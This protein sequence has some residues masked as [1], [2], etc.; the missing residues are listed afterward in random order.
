MSAHR[1]RAAALAAA[2]LSFAACREE[3]SDAYGTF[4][5]AEVVVSAEVGGQLL[6]FAPEEGERVAAG[7]LVAAVDTTP[8]V[9]QRREL[10]ARRGAAG[11]RSR[12]VRAQ[13]DVLEAQRAV[14]QRDY[15]RTRRLFDR[16]A[17]TA[18]Q[19]DAAE[20]EYRV[21]G[22]RIE[23]TRAQGGTVAE[24]A[25]SVDAQVAQIADR[26]RRSRVVN[27]VA[28]VVLATYAERGELVQPGQP[29]YKVAKLDTL[30]LRAYVSG[31]Q[32]PAVRLGQPVRVVVDA[33]GDAL[34]TVSGRVSWIAAQA[35]FT[36]T[37]IQTREERTEQVY[38]V[39]VRVPNPDGALKIGMP[40]ELVLDAARTASTSGRPR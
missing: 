27:P 39:K 38:A 11:G 6:H 2:L 26:I 12:E 1:F 22:E 31:A 20:R 8:L 18:Q 33:G 19:L 21:L 37:P 40:G 32:L 10:L 17:A 35:E 13:I 9:L 14:A 36:P 23:A 25:A 29:L 16:A 7:A 24:E 4:E 15:E 5:A 28:G 3:P 34:R 30:T